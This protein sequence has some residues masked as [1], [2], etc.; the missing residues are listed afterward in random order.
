M[1]IRFTLNGEPT[2]ID[3]D[4]GDLLVDLL[5]L[6]LGLRGARPGCLRGQCGSCTVV[7]DG[8]LAASCLIPAFRVDGADI[9][10]IE[11]LMPTKEYQDIERGFE[12]ARARPCRFCAAGKF[13]SVHVLIESHRE[14][15]EEAIREALAGVWCRCTTH[16][17]LVRGV[18]FAAEYRA[19]RQDRGT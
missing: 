3:A 18:R 14:L 15:S 13:L 9:L 10:T 7:F 17:R 5:R 12:R 16:N 2:E 11:G 8:R 4:P 6:R 19:R 1:T